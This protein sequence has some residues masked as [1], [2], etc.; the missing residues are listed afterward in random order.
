ME[1]NEEFPVNQQEATNYPKLKSNA[2]HL[3]IT[4][5]KSLH[6]LYYAHRSVKNVNLKISKMATP[7][8]SNLCL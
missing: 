3:E 5:C 2:T 7:I 1:P 4:H 8:I 6:P